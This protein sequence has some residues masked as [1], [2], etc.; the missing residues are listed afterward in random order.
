MC[1]IRIVLTFRCPVL[2][3]MIFICVVCWWFYD[4]ISI[5]FC[6]LL[7]GEPGAMGLPGL[8]GLPGAKVWLPKSISSSVP[9][10]NDNIQNKGAARRVFRNAYSTFL[11][12]CTKSAVIP[13][14]HISYVILNGFQIRLYWLWQTWC[15]KIRNIWSEYSYLIELAMC[16]M[17]GCYVYY[18]ILRA[19][20]ENL[21]I[22]FSEMGKFLCMF[23]TFNTY[24]SQ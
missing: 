14:T 22:F 15:A 8:E 16:T 7:Q 20:V 4:K 21:L 2:I 18:S 5:I 23:A 9:N 3:H 10:W 17:K 12:R 13:A 24:D 11:G 1:G 19:G 6:W